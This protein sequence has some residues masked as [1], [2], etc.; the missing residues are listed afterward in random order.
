MMEHRLSMQFFSDL[1]HDTM[2][3]ELFVGTDLLTRKLWG[4]V[5]EHHGV[6][7][8][9]FLPEEPVEPWEASV[10]EVQALLQRAYNYL[11]SKPSEINED[12]TVD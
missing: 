10:E 3:A 9:K 7:V 2:V 1:E 4:V 11:R 12:E 8:L 6:I 5:E